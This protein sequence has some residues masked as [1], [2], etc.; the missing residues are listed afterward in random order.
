MQTLTLTW[1][2]VGGPLHCLLVLQVDRV[3]CNKPRIWLWIWSQ[4]TESPLT[5]IAHSLGDQDLQPIP[6]P[7]DLTYLL[8]KSVHCCRLQAW[9]TWHKGHDYTSINSF[10]LTFLAMSWIVYGNKREM[11]FSAPSLALHHLSSSDNLPC[12]PEFYTNETQID[13]IMKLKDVYQKMLL[14][15]LLV[16][17]LSNKWILHF[18]LPIQTHK[19][20]TLKR[21][22]L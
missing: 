22:L 5:V 15:P 20:I 12:I 10:I 9:L 4:V 19:E 13:R 2:G 14:Y 1:M 18:N 6:S 7:S 21:V 3:M 8:L 11:T 17:E 16:F